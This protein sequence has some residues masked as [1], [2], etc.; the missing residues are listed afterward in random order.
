MVYPA[1]GVV[2][3]KGIEGFSQL[4]PHVRRHAGDRNAL[5][6]VYF[7]VTRAEVLRLFP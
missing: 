1:F 3:A 4:D 2:F 5:W 6:Y 7:A